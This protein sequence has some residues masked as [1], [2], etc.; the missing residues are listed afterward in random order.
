MK[1]IIALICCLG[2]MAIYGCGS[3]STTPEDFSK[4]YV[5]KM[6]GKIPCDLEDLEYTVTQDGDDKATVV[7][8]GEIQ[9]KETLAL[10][11][12]DGKWIAACEAAK[13]DQKAKEAVKKAAPE[14]KKPAH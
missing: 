6:F 4:N 5:K 1:R 3:D 7:I 10:V 11:K 9:Y 13:L 8:E 12:R 2:L 14:T